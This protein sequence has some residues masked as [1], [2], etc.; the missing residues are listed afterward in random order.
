MHTVL[1]HYRKGSLKN[2]IDP[3]G[4]HFSESG[5][6]HRMRFQ[7]NE[8]NKF[9]CPVSYIVMTM[10]GENHKTCLLQKVHR[11]SVSYTF[12][13]IS[14][15]LLL[16]HI[17]ILKEIISF[18]M[19]LSIMGDW[20]INFE[21]RA[22]MIWTCRIMGQWIELSIQCFN[23]SER[24]TDCTIIDKVLA[25]L[26]PVANEL[27]SHQSCKSSDSSAFLQS[28]SCKWFCMRLSNYSHGWIAI[29]EVNF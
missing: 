4:F 8:D 25:Q 18:V 29:S 20:S 3:V 9:L 13:L 17:F 28:C 5:R 2:S 26:V 23:Q 12:V 15:C 14:L 27:R 6:S 19:P 7:S 11:W 16:T 22:S 1:F 10:R 21:R 24:S